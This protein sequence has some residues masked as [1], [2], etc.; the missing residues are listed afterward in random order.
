MSADVLLFR[1]QSVEDEQ[2]I[3][4]YA[5][6]ALQPEMAHA[7]PIVRTQAIDRVVGGLRQAA[8]GFNPLSDGDP[9]LNRRAHGQALGL[10]EMDRQ[11]RAERIARGGW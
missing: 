1:M 3:A 6:L 10:L 11:A 2:L 9:A 5:L 8:R 7:S 4:Y